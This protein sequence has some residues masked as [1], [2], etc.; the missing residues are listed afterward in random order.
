MGTENKFASEKDLPK[1]VQEEIKEELKREIIGG[2]EIYVEVLPYWTRIAICENKVVRD[3]LIDIPELKQDVAVGNIYK[4]IVQDVIPSMQAVFINVGADRNVYLFVPSKDKTSEYKVG[5]EII[6]QV[7]KES[8]DGKGAKVTTNPTLPGKYVVLTFEKKNGVSKKIKSKFERNRLK[9]IVQRL[10]EEISGEFGVV[11]RTEA[12]NVPDELIIEDLHRVYKVMKDIKYK[13]ENVPAPTIL[14]SDSDIIKKAVRDYASTNL[15]RFIS[16]SKEALSKLSEFLQEFLPNMVGNVEIIYEDEPFLFQKYGLEN[17]FFNMLKD[18]IEIEGGIKLVFNETEAFTAVDVNTASFT[19]AENLDITA[20]QANLMA[21]RE[22]IRQI[23]L[24]KIGGIIIIDLIDIKSRQLKNKMIN[25]I[26]RLAEKS[27]DKTKV[28]GLTRLGLLEISRKKSGY[29]VK[30]TLMSKCPTC[31]EG[32]VNSD[33]L[34]L[35]MT[36]TKINKHRGRIIKVS[37][38]NYKKIDDIVKKLKINV[39]IQPKYGIGKWEIEI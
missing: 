22:A 39:T 17:E 23:E 16:N 31:G 20:Y 32:F 27:K 37:P 5:Q 21:I 12:E 3:F 18:E 7:K 25:E 34:N 28:F 11:A 1:E 8:I 15:K 19:G 13:I 36:M 35:H 30:R 33:I 9:K 2:Q 4:G 14:W 38:E 6:V 29:S 26:K 24:R 10:S